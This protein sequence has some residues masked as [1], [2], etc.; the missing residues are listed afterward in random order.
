MTTKLE[1]RVTCRGIEPRYFEGAWGR[2]QAASYAKG[3]PHLHPTIWW[4]E[5][6][7]RGTG[8]WIDIADRDPNTVTEVTA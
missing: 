6:H 3:R 4:R 1:W 8:P 2:Y 5:N 7:G